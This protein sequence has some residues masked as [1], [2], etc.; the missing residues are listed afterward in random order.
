MMV[1]RKSMKGV[2]ERGRGLILR[3]ELSWHLPGGNEE[4]NETHQSG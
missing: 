1:K 4:N 2:K 3:Q